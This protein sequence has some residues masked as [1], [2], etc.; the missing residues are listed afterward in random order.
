MW[1]FLSPPE[2]TFWAFVGQGRISGSSW[3]TRQP[4]PVSASG[5]G[6]LFFGQGGQVKKILDRNVIFGYFCLNRKS[7]KLAEPL[8][9]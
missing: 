3:K 4:A 5:Q 9:S 2:Q 8:A 7:E 1:V 6:W